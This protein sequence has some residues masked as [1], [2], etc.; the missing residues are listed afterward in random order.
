MKLVILG[1]AIDKEVLHNPPA[2]NAELE[3]IPF[4]EKL[5]EIFKLEIKPLSYFILDTTKLIRELIERGFSHKLDIINK[6]D[7]YYIVGPYGMVWPKPF[8]ALETAKDIYNKFAIITHCT[9]LP[10]KEAKSLGYLKTKKDG[11]N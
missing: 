4:L 11:R 3:Y 6:K 7:A 10:Y 2:I 9:I 5:L 1:R 8:Y